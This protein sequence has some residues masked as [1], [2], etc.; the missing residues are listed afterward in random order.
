MPEHPSDRWTTAAAYETYMGRW[1]R[2][3]AASFVPWLRPADGWRWLDVGCGTGALTAAIADGCRPRTVAG[4]D[5]SPDFVAAARDAAPSAAGF[6]VADASALPVA[7][8]SC[9][10]AVSGL[11]LNFFPDQ[12]GA[13]A[14][15]VR[16]VRPG[17]TVAA[18]VWDYT[19]G[20][21][22]LR[23]FWDAA[24]ATD[25]AAGA[26]DERRRFPACHPDALRTLWSAAGLAEVIV[27]PIEVPTSFRDFEALWGP[28]GLGQGPAPGYV[29]TLDPSARERLRRALRRIVPARPDGSVA[30][31]ARAWAVRGQR[32][33]RPRTV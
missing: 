16:A 14:E 25:P 26:V 31:T 17:G 29:A 4:V 5:T 13:V 21:Q 15:A 11:A 22:F 32:P 33:D 20:M 23:L 24:V 7:D 27:V 18:Y 1:S 3:V 28:F 2:A 9:D 12:R 8:G 30:L 6:A 19:D 10:A